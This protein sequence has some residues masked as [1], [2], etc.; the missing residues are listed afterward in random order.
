M[1]RISRIFFVVAVL[2]GISLQVFAKDDDRNQILKVYNWAD[3]IDED[4]ITEFE[5]WYKQQTGEDV[6]VIYQTFDINEVMLTKIEKGHEDYDVVCP[7]EYIIERMLRNNLLQPISKDFGSTPDYTKNVSPYAKEQFA[8]SL[9]TLGETKS[10]SFRL[11]D[12]FTPVFL[13]DESYRSAEVLS[14][15]EKDRVSLARSLSLLGAMP[16]ENR[17][18]LLLDDP[19]LSYDDAHL[20]IALTALTRLAKDYQIIYLTCSHSRMP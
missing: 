6:E 9:S 16:G 1:K 5:E 20:E 8:K 12:R 4:L 15:G 2:M 10:E 3:Y 11:G 17:P 18:P 19:F 14:R 7:S 13:S